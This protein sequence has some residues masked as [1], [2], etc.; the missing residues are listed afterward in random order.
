MPKGKRTGVPRHGWKFC[1]TKQAAQATGMDVSM[2]IAAA[3][4]SKAIQA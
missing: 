2:A 1:K 4:N 3:F